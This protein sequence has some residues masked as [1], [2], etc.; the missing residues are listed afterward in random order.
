MN[1]CW[2]CENSGWDA[3]KVQS[4]WILKKCVPEHICCLASPGKTKE[5]SG[6]SLN[7]LKGMQFKKVVKKWMFIYWGFLKWWVSPTNPWVFL[8]KIIILGCFWGYHH[9]RKH[10]YR[11]TAYISLSLSLYIYIYTYGSAFR[12]PFAPW[13]WVYRQCFVR[14]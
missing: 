1:F 11:Y 13:W 7:L 6:L 5:N 4:P 3:S 9:L 12:S 8:L 14:M 2:G 10:P